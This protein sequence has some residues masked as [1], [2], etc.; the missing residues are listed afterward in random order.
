MN[1]K[2]RSTIYFCVV[3]NDSAKKVIGWLHYPVRVFFLFFF[4]YE[5]KKQE[6]DEVNQELDA[7]CL[8][9]KF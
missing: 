8:A 5:Y 2:S 1:K 9:K 4:A 7:A 6:N 3:S